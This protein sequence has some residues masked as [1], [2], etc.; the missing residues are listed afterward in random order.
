MA[1]EEEKVVRRLLHPRVL[2]GLLQDLYSLSAEEANHN[3]DE[4]IAGLATGIIDCLDSA[5]KAAAPPHTQVERVEK[6]LEA[7]HDFCDYLQG[8][9]HDYLHAD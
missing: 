8:Y 7:V 5:S 4:A 6:S 1:R 9:I 3:D 2:D